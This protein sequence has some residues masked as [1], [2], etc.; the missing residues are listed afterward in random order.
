MSAS[1]KF[2]EETIRMCARPRPKQYDVEIQIENSKVVK[3][4]WSLR[5]CANSRHG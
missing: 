5:C 4:S 3:D 1:Y 2:F